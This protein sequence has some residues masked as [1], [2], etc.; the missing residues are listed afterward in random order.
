[1]RKSVIDQFFKK[2]AYKVAETSANRICY[3]F[4]YQPKLPKSVQKLRRF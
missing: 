2:A 3:L 4:F 1:M